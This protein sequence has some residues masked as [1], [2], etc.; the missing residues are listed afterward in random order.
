MAP[1]PVVCTD[2]GSTIRF[3]MRRECDRPFEALPVQ[4]LA[5]KAYVSPL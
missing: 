2:G 3:P 5:W 1:I 4:A